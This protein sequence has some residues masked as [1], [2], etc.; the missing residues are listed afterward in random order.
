[1]KKLKDLTRAY[2]PVLVGLVLITLFFAACK[3]DDPDYNNNV[4]AAGV[5][6]FNLA[7]DKPA[8]GFTFDANRL[9]NL[10]LDYTNYTGTYL[11]VTPGT[12][13][14]RSAEFYT[15]STIATSSANF[16]D[17]MLYSVFL[18]GANGNYRNLVVQDDDPL[19]TPVAGKAW[20]RY[21]N[22]IPDSSAPVTV[23]IGTGSETAPFTTV[24][25]F[26]QADAGQLAITV[27][28]GGTINASRTIAIEENRVYTILLSGLPGSADPAQAVQIRFIQNGTASQQ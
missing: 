13:V 2:A 10:P 9:G 27:S 7:P 12:R 5:M 18:L 19:V 25:A 24:S 21:I 15:G 28:N 20:V 14:V 3:K 17:S 1:M 11:A 26:R 23:T 6:A 16:T 8:I 22:A 4:P